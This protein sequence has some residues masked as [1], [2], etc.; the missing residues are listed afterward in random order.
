[1]SGTE[2]D[3]QAKPGEQLAGVIVNGYGRRTARWIP[4]V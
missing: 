3:V 1:M 4:F 2:L